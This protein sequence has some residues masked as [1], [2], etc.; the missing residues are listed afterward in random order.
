MNYQEEGHK[1]VLLFLSLLTLSL[2]QA[3]G[4]FADPQS[5]IVQGQ[6]AQPLEPNPPAALPNNSLEIQRQPGSAGT[7]SRTLEYQ[8]GE[9]RDWPSTLSGCW[10]RTPRR[11]E[12]STAMVNQ[13]VLC[14]S[15]HY[16]HL[17][18]ICFDESPNGLISVRLSESRSHTDHWEI[19]DDDPNDRITSTGTIQQTKRY[20]DQRIDLLILASQGEKLQEAGS[21]EVDVSHSYQMQI[22]YARR[23]GMMYVFAG[24]RW[25]CGGAPY[26]NTQ[27]SGEFVKTP[28]NRTR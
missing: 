25:D 26:F 6:T 12:C 7:R 2:V 11:S 19:T 16:F 17:Q 20:S 9:I 5:S 18:E 14:P 28:A 21:H 22:V 1:G 13:H 23:K 15:L 8:P 4:A 27:Q 3:T 10:W 24:G